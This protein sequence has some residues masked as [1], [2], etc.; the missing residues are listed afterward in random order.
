MGLQFNSGGMDWILVLFQ[1]FLENYIILNIEKKIIIENKRDREEKCK[2]NIYNGSFKKIWSRSTSIFT[3]T[4]HSKSI[5][6][7]RFNKYLRNFYKSLGDNTLSWDFTLHNKFLEIPHSIN[8]LEI[9]HSKFI[10]LRGLTLET[11][12]GD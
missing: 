7:L 3:H 8:S 9:S 4:I 11:I 6:P 5:D 10:P 2:Y 1:M 12:I